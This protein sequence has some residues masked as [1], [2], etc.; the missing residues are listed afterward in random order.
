MK[1]KASPVFDARLHVVA[2]KPL[3]RAAA[4]AAAA[5]LCSLNSYVRQALL[6]QLKLDGFEPKEAA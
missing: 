2:T 6:R 5:N 3:A 4:A 1:G